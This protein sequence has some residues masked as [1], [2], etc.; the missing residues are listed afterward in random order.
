M[1]GNM[2]FGMFLGF[3]GAL[4]AYLIGA[5]MASGQEAMQYF[6]AWG[7]IPALLTVMIVNFI[8][9]FCTLM[10]YTYAGRKGTVDLQTV[11]EYYVGKKIGTLFTA[12]AWIF[13]AC[14]YLFMISGFG[15]TMNQQFGIPMWAGCAIAVALSVGTA[16]FGLSGIVNIIG[17]I[18][19]VVVGMLLLLAII[20]GIRLFPNI[21]QGVEIV[22]SGKLE[23][24][25]AGATPLL[26]GLSY[27]GCSV[28]LVAGYMSKIGK[29]LSGYKK[30]YTSSLCLAAALAITVTV[31]LLGMCHLGN[32]EESSQAAI[33]N[34]LL[35][36][37][38]FGPGAS[39]VFGPVF[40]IVI[41]ASIYSTFCPIMWTCVSTVI[42]DDRSARYKIVCAAVGIAVFIIDM[43]IPY[44]TLVNVILTYCGY[45]GGIVF[46]VLS[47]SWIVRLVR[48]KRSAGE[49]AE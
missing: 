10:A 16:V 22:Q 24:L 43:F 34:L 35:A 46:A 38:V 9:M 33:P 47:V 48:D 40:A 15:N 39:K 36:N 23:L 25:R 30:R 17:K 18:G 42:K 1:N 28:L 44:A 4:L 26:G 20:A 29:D 3:F 45:T 8:V 27:G 12:F 11:C 49:S 13:N 32:I 14:C 2:S 7:S 5:G 41:L 6:T 19:P 37:T 31:G 21:P